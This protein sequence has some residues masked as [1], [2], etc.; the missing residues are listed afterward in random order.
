[1]ATVRRRTAVLRLGG[2]AGGS[3]LRALDVQRLYSYDLTIDARAVATGQIS[4][5]LGDQAWRDFTAA[6]NEAADTPTTQL[7]E[8]RRA[9]ETVKS[10]GR[11]MFFSLVQ[12]HPSL[13]AYLA[14]SGPRRLVISSGYP[15]LHA[16][17]W[18]ALI[19][20]QWRHLAC[21]DLSIVHASDVFE[22]VSEPVQPPLTIA[23]IFGPETEHQ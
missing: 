20:E 2:V 13:R 19:D 15:E 4:S 10:A 9:F 14:D 17:P 3:E 23:K 5:P 21:T 22:P 8:R 16:L 12:L 7:T 1:M 18:E 11:Q 6:L